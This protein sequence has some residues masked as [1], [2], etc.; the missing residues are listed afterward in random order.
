MHKLVKISSIVKRQPW[1]RLNSYAAHSV[2]WARRKQDGVQIMSWRYSPIKVL[3]SNLMQTKSPPD[4]DGGGK[5]IVRYSLGGAP[6]FHITQL[7]VGPMFSNLR[8]SFGPHTC[9]PSRFCWG[10][11]LFY[12][13]CPSQT[14]LKAGRSGKCV[15]LLALDKWDN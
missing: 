8:R 12:A 11:P 1:N 10:T 15:I 7:A 4:G 14:I 2:F 6:V 5:S 9:Q 3:D 13:Q